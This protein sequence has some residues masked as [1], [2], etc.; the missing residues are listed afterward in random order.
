MNLYDY[1]PNKI[2]RTKV[3]SMTT[4]LV[5]FVYVVVSFVPINIK[6]YDYFEQKKMYMYLSIC[7]G[8]FC[9]QCP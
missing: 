1:I 2:H 9:R 5:D 8:C 3:N 6:M 7:M 4:S